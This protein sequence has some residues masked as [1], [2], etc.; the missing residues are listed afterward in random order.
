MGQQF[1]L[2]RYYGPLV[3]FPIKKK[4]QAQYGGWWFMPIIPA[5]RR[6]R[7]KNLEFEANVSYTS[8]SCL[9]K[10]INKNPPDSAF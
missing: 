6:L 3:L 5:L 2:F 4:K 7:Q 10:Q 1:L 9:K 8:R